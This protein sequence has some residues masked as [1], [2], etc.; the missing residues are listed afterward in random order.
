MV[1]VQKMRDCGV[2]RSKRDICVTL[3][4]QQVS[5]LIT[6]EGSE[7][8]NM[9]TVDV[10]CEKGLAGHDKTVTHMNSRSWDSM[11]IFA[12]DGEGMLKKSHQQLM[13]HW[14][15][16]VT[17]RGRVMGPGLHSSKQSHAHAYTSSI[18]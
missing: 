9:G 3:P 12:Q 13:C 18:K 1:S 6:E 17:E 5:E 16:I 7:R 8:K 14:Q 4:P 2:L 11:H 15:L 10:C